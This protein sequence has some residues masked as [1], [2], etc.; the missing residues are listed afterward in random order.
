MGEIRKYTTKESALPIIGP[1]YY[2]S[3]VWDSDNPNVYGEGIG[4]TKEEAE[5]KALTDFIRKSSREK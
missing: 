1:D 5:T 3:K 2:K 4:K